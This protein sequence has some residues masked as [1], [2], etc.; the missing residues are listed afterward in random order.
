VAADRRP[1]VGVRRVWPF[2]PRW[3]RLR[4]HANRV[5]QPRSRDSLLQALRHICGRARDVLPGQDLETRGRQLAV[6]KGVG[7][8]VKSRHFVVRDRS[9]QHH[10]DPSFLRPLQCRLD[11]I[12]GF[13][14]GKQSRNV[15]PIFRRQTMY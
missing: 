12:E 2:D 15:G 1:G 5:R 7:S 10:G 3:I 9:A 6:R 14:L 11:P 4:A 8:E 13:S